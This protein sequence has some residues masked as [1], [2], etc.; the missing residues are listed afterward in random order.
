M[1]FKHSRAEMIIC[2][3]W[4]FDWF[5]Y[6]RLVQ[7]LSVIHIRLSVYQLAFDIFSVFLVNKTPIY[8]VFCQLALIDDEYFPPEVCNFTLD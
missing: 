6:S 8:L 4:K 2:F 5:E 1:N 3:D 7:F